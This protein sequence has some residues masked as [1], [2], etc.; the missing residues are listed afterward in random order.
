MTY[1]V[2]K[3]LIIFLLITQVCGIK[4]NSISPNYVYTGFSSQIETHFL[5]ANVTE[6]EQLGL[7]M[8]IGLLDA[9]FDR[10]LPNSSRVYCLNQENQIIKDLSRQA[11]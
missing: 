3:I 8:Y 6:S 11:G 4:F 1:F 5:Q 9:D 7:M 10:Q 2:N